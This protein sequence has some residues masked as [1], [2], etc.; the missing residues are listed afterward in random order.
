MLD[1][2]R[3]TLMSVAAVGLVATGVAFVQGGVCFGV[4]VGIVA[5]LAVM[6]AVQVAFAFARGPALDAYRAALDRLRAD[7]TNPRV[8]EE[9]LALGRTYASLTADMEGKPGYT[10]AA[11]QNDLQAATGGR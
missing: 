8:R 5:F 7:P 3:V 11:I 9:A 1:V 2:A 10:E 6:V 4:V